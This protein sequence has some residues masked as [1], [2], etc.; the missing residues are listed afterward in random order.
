VAVKGRRRKRAAHGEGCSFYS[1]QRRL[2]NGDARLW[3]ARATVKPWVAKRRRPWSE[4]GRH[5]R[6]RC[7]DRVA[8]EWCPHG[9][10]FS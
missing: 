7:S 6:R 10:A 1:R 5:G 3:A 2:A 8:D 4:R 9:F